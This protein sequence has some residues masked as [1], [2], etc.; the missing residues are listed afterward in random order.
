MGQLVICLEHFT[1]GLWLTQTTSPP[2]YLL[3]LERGHGQLHP[4]TPWWKGSTFRYAANREPPLWTGSWQPESAEQSPGNS[5]VVGS[6]DDFLLKQIRCVWLLAGIV[7][8]GVDFESISSKEASSFAI[9][10]AQRSS[11]RSYTK[12]E[13][14]R[15]GRRIEEKERFWDIATNRMVLGL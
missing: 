8:S 1:S 6:W 5:G 11:C 14:A 13:K 10:V 12:A 4:G 7:D 15:T 3:T 2:S 9:P